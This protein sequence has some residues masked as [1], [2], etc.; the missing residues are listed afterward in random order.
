METTFFYKNLKA[1]EEKN[2]FD[3]ANE[4]LAAIESLLTSFADDAKLLK[5]SIKKFNKHDAYSV[6]LFLTLPAVNLIA[7]EASH[8][9]SKAID[10]AKDRLI[11]Q[12]KKHIAQLRK[13]RAHRSIRHG[14]TITA[15][16]KTSEPTSVQN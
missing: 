13:D 14:E 5:I 6:E 10:Q 8:A 12:I 16:L 2:F 9:F 3:Y 4:K 11:S 1:E 15:K 7:R